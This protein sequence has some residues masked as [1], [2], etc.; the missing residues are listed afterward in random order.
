[1][2]NKSTVHGYTKGILDYQQMVEKL[3]QALGRHTYHTDEE[4]KT[5][6][7]V[8]RIM[9]KNGGH[10]VAVQ[11][12]DYQLAAITFGLVFSNDKHEVMPNYEV[13]ACNNQRPLLVEMQTYEHVGETT[14]VSIKDIV[15]CYLDQLQLFGDFHPSKNNCVHFSKRFVAALVKHTRNVG[16]VSWQCEATV[17]RLC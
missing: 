16:W 7:N 14:D 13:T 1:M 12:V 17:A 15:N 8:Y 2:G 9:T 4:K 3:Q 10:L 6:W 11:P 5:N